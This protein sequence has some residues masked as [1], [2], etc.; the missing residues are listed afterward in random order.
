RTETTRG[1]DE[2]MTTDAI[3]AELRALP[4]APDGLR[5]RVRALPEPQPRFRF[6]LPTRRVLLVAVPAVLV[7]AVGAAAV[8]G[9]LNGSSK[10]VAQPVVEQQ[11][12]R[13]GIGGGSSAPAT[14]TTQSFGAV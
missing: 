8:H 5:A 14:T 12:V 1:V 11:A 13:H 10:P 9:L 6:E 3:I 4:G 2:R 7:V